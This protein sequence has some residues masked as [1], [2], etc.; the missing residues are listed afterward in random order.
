MPTADDR[1]L[2]LPM[3]SAYTTDQM[4]VLN[5]HPGCQRK[6]RQLLPALEPSHQLPLRVGFWEDT[7]DRVRRAGLKAVNRWNREMKKEGVAQTFSPWEVGDHGRADLMIGAKMFSWGEAD[8]G[9]VASG[10]WGKH[11]FGAPLGG[12]EVG[13][14]TLYWD[15][16]H[17]IIGGK[18]FCPG[19]AAEAD[20][21]AIL[22][23]EL[24][25]GL[26]LGHEP[27][28]PGLLMY[29][30]HTAV[31][32]PSAMERRWVEEIWV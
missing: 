4:R 24:G 7:P 29:R 10:A 28:R 2:R 16:Q 27:T 8:F 32:K 22:A 18:I 1:R 5:W 6:L 31:K 20:C 9:S 25:H 17:R 19:D 23:H 14:C 30:T 3:A 21:A 11:S 26:L 13:E 12:S 15:L